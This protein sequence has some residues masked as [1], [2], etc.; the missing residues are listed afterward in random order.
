[1]KTPTRKEIQDVIQKMF[2]YAFLH[3]GMDFMKKPGAAVRRMKP[4][5]RAILKHAKAE[6][7]N[8]RV[9]DLFRRP[10]GK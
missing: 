5:D 8:G 4:E 2:R 10:D 1:M 9:K 6:D 7:F 3:S